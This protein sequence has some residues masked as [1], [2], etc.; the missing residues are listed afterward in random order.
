MATAL[1][2]QQRELL[3]CGPS[4]FVLTVV[5][6]LALAAV[7]SVR[8]FLDPHNIFCGDEECYAVLGLKR[9]A[10]KADI[11]KAYRTISLDVHPDK[12]SSAAAKEKFTVR[13]CVLS[14]ASKEENTGQ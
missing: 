2:K 1:H 6:V 7:S 9:G 8:A 10:D 4:R 14:A 5:S 3:A 13:A 11:K 12:N